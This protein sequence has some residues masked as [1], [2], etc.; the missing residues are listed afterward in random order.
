MHQRGNLLF[1]LTLALL[2]SYGTVSAQEIVYDFSGQPVLL[3]KYEEYEGS[4]FMYDEWK[5]GS[6]KLKN[7][8]SY[9]DLDLKYDAA[10]DRV[11]FKD[12]L[13]NTYKF[14]D[15]VSE[16]EINDLLFRSGYAAN[17]S[18][19]EN[20]FYQVLV[21]GGTQLLKRINKTITEQKTYGS[22]VLKKQFQSTESFYMVKAGE[23]RK[24]KKDK[25]AIYEVLGNK[26][27]EM[28][29][30]IA[31]NKLNLKIDNDMAM[32]ISYYNSL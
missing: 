8:K 2:F 25:K 16:F 24:I 5:K 13:G 32:L 15:P 21:D 6:V 22:A 20:S 23:I 9:S 28:D 17:E 18:R 11:L 26:A 31:S 14:D 19:T 1:V 12:K 3:K 27:A 10:E 4:P 7:G 29:N 30:Y